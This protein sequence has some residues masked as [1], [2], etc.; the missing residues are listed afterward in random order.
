MS[1]SHYPPIET[2]PLGAIRKELL[3][4][5]WRQ[6]ARRDRRRRAATALST[7]MVT[8]VCAVGGASALGWDVPLIGDPLDRWITGKQ[9]IAQSPDLDP[10]APIGVGDIKPGAGNSTEPLSFPWAGGPDTAAAAAYLNT[11]DQVCFVLEGPDGG[12]DIGGCTPPELISDRLEDAAAYLVGVRADASIVVWG[13]VADDVDR[14]SV[15]G[16]QGPLEVRL[17]G[18]WTPAVEGAGQMRAFVAVSDARA[19]QKG[20]AGELIDPD[21]YT[22]GATLRDGRTVTVR[23]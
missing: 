16:P 9:E 15:D 22:V 14:V 3:A 5:G 18:P 17:S 8:L 23:R 2:D 12:L 20:V 19:A 4:A 6:K 21:A 10:T 13:Y 1:D 7:V 11:R